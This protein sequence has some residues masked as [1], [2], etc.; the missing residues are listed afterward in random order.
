MTIIIIAIMIVIID[1]YIYTHTFDI[2]LYIY[3]WDFIGVLVASIQA[4]ETV[5]QER[6]EQL[7]SLPIGRAWEGTAI[8]SHALVKMVPPKKWMDK[9][10]RY[11]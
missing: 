11:G 9:S 7:G 3:I 8:A 1:N 4:P 2:Q 6:L 5:R 10:D